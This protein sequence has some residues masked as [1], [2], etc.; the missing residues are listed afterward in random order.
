MFCSKCG[1]ELPNDSQFCRKCS[2]ALTMV[3]TGGGAA[4]VASAPIAPKPRRRVA[5]L[6][7]LNQVRGP[8]KAIREL[9]ITIK[10]GVS[11]KVWRRG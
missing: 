5:I 9:A 4:P 1:R 6:I 11:N 2:R 10:T 7:P 8:S 3:S